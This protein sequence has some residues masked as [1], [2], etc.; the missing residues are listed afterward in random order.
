[1]EDIRGGK[2]LIIS[3]FLS[4]HSLTRLKLK[5]EALVLADGVFGCWTTHGWEMGGCACWIGY[6]RL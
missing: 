1:M 2:Y 4:S 5:K 3:N 6:K